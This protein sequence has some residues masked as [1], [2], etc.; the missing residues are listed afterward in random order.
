MVIVLNDG[1]DKD[2]VADLFEGKRLEIEDF[3]AQCHKQSCAKSMELFLSREHFQADDLS[4]MLSIA[5][6]QQQLANFLLKK[7][8]RQT[9]LYPFMLYQ[10]FIL[11]RTKILINTD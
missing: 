9:C 3:I 10:Q 2:L 6:L 5:G 7:K 4:P 11:I 1:L 8:N